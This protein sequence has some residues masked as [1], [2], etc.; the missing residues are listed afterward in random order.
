MEEKT[1]NKLLKILISLYIFLKFE[2][3]FFELVIVIYVCFDKLNSGLLYLE[4]T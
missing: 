1:E 2:N 4:K 3:N